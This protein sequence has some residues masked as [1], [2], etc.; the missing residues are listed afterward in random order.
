VLTV[1][2][3]YNASSTD[4]ITI[5]LY[6][7]PNDSSFDDYPW[8]TYDIPNCRQVG[9]TS[10]DYE[11]MWGETVTSQAAG[12]ATVTGWT[13][14]SGTWAGGDAAGNVY[15][16]DI[17]GTFTDTQTLTGGTSSCAAVQNGSIAAHAIVR[18][19]YPLAVVPLYMKCRL[20]NKDTT[21]DITSASLIAIKQT[22]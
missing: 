10:G 22:I 19:M 16:Q 15:L 17:S 14:S 1:N 20:H 6:T 3:T 21:Y 18:T 8:D 7:S 12:T 11:W 4:G 9:Y 2:A 5:L 13:L